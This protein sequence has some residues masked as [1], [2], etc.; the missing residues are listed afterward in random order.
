[1][2]VKK[3]RAGYYVVTYNGI[4]YEVREN[5]HFSR[6]GIYRWT[7]HKQ[8]DSNP[9]PITTGRTFRDVKDHIQYPFS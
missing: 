7:A 3:I 8:R 1:M 4:T 9:H 2:Q 6:S 5:P